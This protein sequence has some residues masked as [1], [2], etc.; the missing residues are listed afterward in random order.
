MQNLQ[1]KVLNV[2]CDGCVAAIQTGLSLISGVSNILV[3]KENGI[4]NVSGEALDRIKL[5]SKLKEL[6]YPELDIK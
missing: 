1:I 5:V 6:G 4:V 2:K 3:S